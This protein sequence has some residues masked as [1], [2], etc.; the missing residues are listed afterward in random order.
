MGSG[1]V[2]ALVAVPFLFEDQHRHEFVG[3]DFFERDPDAKFQCGA[4]IE[5]AADEES[6][7]AV[8]RFVDLVERAVVAPLAIRSIR[9]EPRITE[10]VAPKGPVD[11]IAEGRLLRPLLR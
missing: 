5:R 6:G 8:L 2:L 10:I 1:C 9:T 11:E 3:A 4:Q 7:L